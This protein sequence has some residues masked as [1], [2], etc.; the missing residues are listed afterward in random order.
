MRYYEITNGFKLNTIAK[1]LH[2]PINKQLESEMQEVINILHELRISNQ[3]N[4]KS[5]Q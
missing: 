5:I 2:K 4:T 1:S 3:S